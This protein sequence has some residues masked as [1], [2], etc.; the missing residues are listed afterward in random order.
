MIS[1]LERKSDKYFAENHAA[2]LARSESWQRYKKAEQ[3]SK[4]FQWYAPVE[5]FSPIR[6]LALVVIANAVHEVICRPRRSPVRAPAA[7]EWLSNWGLVGP[8]C[9]A[10]GISRSRLKRRI[11]AL[12][13]ETSATEPA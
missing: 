8:W 2:V 1:A 3:P 11:T 6:K 9:E 12:G 5:P 13:L 10:A 7:T 4:E